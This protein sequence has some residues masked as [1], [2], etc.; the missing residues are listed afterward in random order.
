MQ[1]VNLLTIELQLRAKDQTVIT[2]LKNLKNLIFSLQNEVKNRLLVCRRPV[3]HDLDLP[4]F[5]NNVGVVP[6]VYKSRSSQ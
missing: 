5:Q 2:F 3:F 1:T 4:L 6:G